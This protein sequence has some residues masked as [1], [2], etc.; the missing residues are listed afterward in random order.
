MIRSFIYIITAIYSDLTFTVSKFCQFY[1]LLT[2][3]NWSDLQWEFWY[4]QELKNTK[5]IYLKDSHKG[6]FKISDSDYT[7]DAENRKFTHKYVFTL[8]REVISWFSQKQ[9]ITVTLI[10]KVKYVR[11]CSA[12]KTAVWVIEWLKEVNLT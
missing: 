5:I 11:L 8:V 3:W 4:L 6:I 1:H 7:E 10:T 12:V 9:K 2:V